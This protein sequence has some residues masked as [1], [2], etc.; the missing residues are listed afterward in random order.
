M[1]ASMAAAF[2]QKSQCS[3][4]SKSYKTLRHTRSSQFIVYSK[5]SSHAEGAENRQNKNTTMIK[6]A[7]AKQITAFATAAAFLLP[8]ATQILDIIHPKPA[9]AVLSAPNARIARSVDAALRRSIPAFN[10][11]VRIIQVCVFLHVFGCEYSLLMNVV[12]CI[13]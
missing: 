10:E 5:Q 11:N 9:E 12:V 2:Q 7:I 6:H 3:I 1:P 13:I 8:P 4:L